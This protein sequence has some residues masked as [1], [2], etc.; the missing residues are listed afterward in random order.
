MFTKNDLNNMLK[1]STEHSPNLD[2]NHMKLMN[3]INKSNLSSQE[4]METLFDDK[5]K[6]LI[7]SSL[8]FGGS[9]HSNNNANNTMNDQAMSSLIDSKLIDFKEDIIRMENDSSMKLHHM[10]EEMLFLKDQLHYFDLYRIENISEIQKLEKA[11]QVESEQLK[12]LQKR[13]ANLSVDKVKSSFMPHVSSCSDSCHC[14]S[15]LASCL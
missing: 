6:R 7:N 10:E 5:L 15:F 2:N 12:I 3:L 13:I 1:A 9:N 11:R 14:V 8:M 4:R